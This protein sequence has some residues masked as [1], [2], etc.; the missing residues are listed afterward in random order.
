MHATG[1]GKTKPIG[2]KFEV[3]SLKCEVKKQTQ[4]GRRQVALGSRDAGTI[5]QNKANLGWSGRTPAA[6]MR[7]TNPIS[8]LVPIRRS[9]FP[10]SERAKQSQSPDCG[11]RILDCGFREP[12]ARRRGRRG[13]VVQTNPI[14]PA[15]PNPGGRNAPNKPNWGADCAKQTQFAA[16]RAA[17][18]GTDHAKQ[19]QLPPASC[20]A[21]TPNP[22][23]AEGQSCETKPIWERPQVRGVRGPVGRAICTTN[24]QQLKTISK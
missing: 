19:S 21:R 11:L 6:E 15:G 24:P 5:M 16:R 10:G 1:F 13:A 2:R 3:G 12:A 9:A 14:S 22:R 8:A 20:R 23:R 7:Q 4:S 17:T 18:G